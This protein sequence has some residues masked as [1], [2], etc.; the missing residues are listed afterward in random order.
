MTDT[1]LTND[2]IVE[3]TKSKYDKTKLYLYIAM[4]LSSWGDR[5]WSFAVGIY[6]ISLNPTNLQGVAINGVVLNLAVILFG[7]AIGIWIDHN[8]RLPTLRKILLIQNCSVA[9]MAILVVIALY[10]QSKFSANWNIIIQGMLIG[11]GIIATLSSM[12]SKISI[13]KDWVVVLYGSDRQNLANTNATIRRIDLISNVLAPIATGAIMA[14]TFRWV[15]AVFIAGWNVISLG[16]EWFLYTKVY[17]TAENVLSH[18]ISKTNSNQESSQVEEGVVTKLLSSIQGLGTYGSLSVCL[19]GLSL[20]LLYMTVLSFDSVTRAYVIDQGLSEVV[21]GGL[22]GL[23]SVIGV[24][25]TFMY[26]V[27][28]KHNGLVRTGVIGFW[29]EFSMLLL[30]LSSLFVH[31]STFAPYE[32]LT[33]YS[34]H[35][36]STINPVS[37]TN[38]IPYYCLELNVSVLLLIIGITFNRFGLWV[39]DLTVNQLQQERV[40][41]DIRG[42]IGGT[43][44]ALNQFFDM[45]RYILIIILPKMPEFGYHVCL[46][47]LSVFTASLIYTIWSCS[48]SSQLVPPSTDIEMCETNAELSKTSQ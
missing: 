27:F 30:C 6:F 40:P 47:V 29:S 17:R 42:R 20:A 36:N 34:C 8:P 31:G 12:A 10:D 25:G 43:Q 13:S 38:F 18:K 1:H 5:M 28:V 4:S 22:N 11:I 7:T 15:S 37:T 19:P 26:P 24:I 48:S 41:E 3:E 39:V 9:F 46:S 44:S 2:E 45:L 21:L 32:I 35:L 23:G 14:F 16:L 33:G